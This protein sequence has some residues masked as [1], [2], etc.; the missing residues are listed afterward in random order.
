MELLYANGMKESKSGLVVYEL[1]TLKRGL[2]EGTRLVL[3]I[4]IY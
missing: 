4:I 2:F 1:F 3:F